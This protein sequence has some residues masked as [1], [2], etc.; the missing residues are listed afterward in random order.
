M[1][2][3]LKNQKGFTLIEAL[4]IILILV[5]IGGI[6][7]MVYHNDH[8]TKAVTTSNTAA[9]ATTSRSSA[10]Q[11]TENSDNAV[12]AND[13][14]SLLAAFS[15]FQANNEGAPPTTVTAAGSSTAYLCASTTCDS[16]NSSVVNLG[17]YKPQNISISI[18]EHLTVPDD[19]TVYISGAAG[20]VNKTTAEH[21]ND[22]A[23]TVVLY[24][25]Q[26]GNTITQQCI[27]QD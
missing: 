12:R 9:K 22:A 5:V 8:K 17:F 26:N 10:S 13:A 23:S 14:N 16:T 27:G 6:G 19:K 20:C 18:G 21:T 2:K 3:T 25:L 24:A 15:N 11:V 1:N 4:L 7:Y